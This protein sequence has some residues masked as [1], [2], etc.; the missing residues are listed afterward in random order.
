ML[1]WILTGAAFT[2]FIALAF[3][4]NHK[5]GQVWD[6]PRPRIIPWKLVMVVAAFGAILALVHAVNLAGF[7]TGPEHSMFGRF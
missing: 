2:A 5:A 1:H 7:E 4:A 6:D 3:L